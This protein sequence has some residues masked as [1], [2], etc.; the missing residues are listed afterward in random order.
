[1]ITR[2]SALGFV[3]GGPAMA[4]S[5][6]RAS[7]RDLV[8]RFNRDR[9]KFEQLLMRFRSDSRMSRIEA[10]RG[11][12]FGPPQIK[13]KVDGPPLSPEAKES[14]ETLMSAL[15]LS[16]LVR[17]DERRLAFYCAD[18]DFLIRYTYTAFV[19]SE[20]RPENLVDHLYGN[21][22]DG[23]RRESGDGAFVSY[24]ALSSNWYLMTEDY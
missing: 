13:L 12:P 19:W 21:G 15:K 1:M 5:G 14:Y 18:T 22:P 20:T 6:C 10:E 3:I 7:E 4:L 16:S 11:P 2:R 23:Y 24:K 8:R 17:A 9:P